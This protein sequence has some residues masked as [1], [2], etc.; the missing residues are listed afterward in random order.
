MGI[1]DM[2]AALVVV[3]GLALTVGAASAQ[4]AERKVT[5]IQGLTGNPFYTTV[6]CGGAAAAKALGVQFSAQGPRQWDPALQTQ[7]LNAVMAA[8]PDA[9][10][11]SV[12]DPVAMVPALLQAKEQGIKIVTIDGDT[13]RDD[14][15]VTNIQSDNVKGGTL[16]GQTMAELLGGKG[17]VMALNNAPGTDVSSERLDGF[18]AA[19]KA[20]PGITFLGVQY[21]GN[22]TA[23]AAALVSSTM[24]AHP[25]LAGVFAI[26]TNN[27]EGAVTG[28]RESQATGRIKVVGFDTSDPI[29]EDIR[30]GLVDADVVQFP[31][32]VGQIGLQ[33]AVAALD[34]KPV[35]RQQRT[36]FILATPKNID[37]AEVQHFVYKTHC[38]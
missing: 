30:K 3:S 15:A 16:A 7:V 8:H 23:K 20:F 29:V 32:G 25:H 38:S 12:N 5:Y 9:I 17:E 1:H 18:K 13:N 31:Y 11:I 28:V 33:S 24:A 19:I 27:T 14:L 36:P 34:G 10:M 22:Q 6:A 2:R 4:A 35:E 26:T 21:S 37:T